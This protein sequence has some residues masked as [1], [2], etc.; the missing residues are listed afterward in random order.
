VETP[1]PFFVV[2]R[3]VIV[4]IWDADVVKKGLKLWPHVVIFLN[5]K[6]RFG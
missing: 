5:V 2:F 4:P 3:A 1:A 6:S